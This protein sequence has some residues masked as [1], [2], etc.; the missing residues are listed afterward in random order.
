LFKINSN[1]KIFRISE[2]SIFDNK[3]INIKNSFIIV[4]LVFLISCN[5]QQQETTYNS[6]APKVVE[7]KG[8]VVPKDSMAIPKSVSAGNPKVIVADKSTQ[9]SRRILL[10]LHNTTAVVVDKPTVVPLR[11]NIHLAGNPKTVSAGTPKI[12]TPGRDSFSLPQVIKA[13]CTTFVPGIPEMVVAKDGFSKDQ[14]PQNFSSFTTLE[15]L[16]KGKT[17]SLLQDRNGNVWI[18]SW[19]GGVVRYDGKYFTRFTKKEGLPSNEVWSLLEDKVGNIWFGTL[20][21]VTKYDGKTFTNYTENGLLNYVSGMLED[22]DGN[23]WFASDGG[24]AWK[25]AGDTLTHYTEKEGLYFSLNSV[26]QDKYGHL[27]F[28]TFGGG[29]IEFDNKSF[30]HFTRK[31]GL[32]GNIAGHFLEDQFGN[33]WFVSSGGA[34]KYDGTTFTHYT[35]QE[36]LI[37]NGVKCV[38]QDKAGNFWFGTEGGF[39]KYDGTYFTN[40]TE[41]DGLINNVVNQIIQDSS[42]NFWIATENGLSRYNG[43]VF[44]HFT[45]KEGLSYNEI[46]SISED[47]S[48]NMWFGPNEGDLTKYDGQALTYYAESGGLGSMSPKNISGD[49]AGNFGSVDGRVVKYDGKKWFHYTE[50]EVLPNYESTGVIKDKSGNIWISFRLGGAMKYDGN[51]FT[52]LTVKEGLKNND[53]WLLF[54]DKAGNL[55]FAY[56]EGGV[57]RYDGT[58]TFTHYGEKEGLGGN[59]VSCIAEDKSGNLWFGTE[60]GLIRYDGKTFTHLTV[61]E[62]LS[63]NI[64]TSILPDRAG[65]LWIGTASG[66]NKLTAG[67]LLKLSAY[68]RSSKKKS[69]FPEYFNN[70]DSG[71]VLLKSYTYEDGF[72]GIGCNANAIFEDKKGIIWIGTNDRLTAYHSE[73]DQKD[74]IPPN[75]QLTGVALF[76]ENIPWTDLEHKKDTSFVLG[77]GVS[78]QNFKFDEI[79]NWYYI[80]EHLSLP[81]NNNYLTFSFIGITTKSP[82]QVKYRY[83]LEGLDE[84]WSALTSI[85]EATYG[86]LPPRNY[87][88]KIRA[89]NGDGYWSKEFNYSFTIRP[90]WWQTWWFRTL[91]GIAALLLF[92]GIYRWRTATLRRQKRILEQTVK[93]RTAEVVEEKAEVEKRNIVIQKEKEKSDELLLNIL[94]SEVADELKEKGYTTA[95]A[96]DEVTVLF[97]DIKGFTNVAENM[98]AQ[99]LV[100][101]INTYFSA[102]DG[103]IQKYGLEKIKTIGDAY[104]AAGGLPEKNSATAQNVIEAAID[105]QQVVEKLKQERTFLSKPYFELRIGIHTGPVVAGVVGIKK[106]QY[107]IWGD[108]VNLA[109]RMEQSGVPGKINISQHTYELVKDQFNCAYRGKIEAKNKGDIDMYFVR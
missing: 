55:W 47:K 62:G 87:I 80:P 85:N 12:C 58:K 28:G 38:F 42:G 88:F 92:Y 107:D 19:E 95:K 25:L 105:M 54:T 20:G 7:V 108:T 90:P 100:K 11:R 30:S 98:T 61:K 65:N 13:S 69:G 81:Y 52:H 36:G 66:L 43:E 96:F 45:R 23:I 94:P 1:Q 18:G 63:N 75:I 33:L 27:W 93:E 56:R 8:Y 76:N 86:N 17:V 48:G 83:K 34:T 4:I 91:V 9:A 104:I 3:R 102:F 79:S 99:E 73:G 68:A 32:A 40:F 50:K 21:G 24:G 70:N 59:S 49:S 14:N 77:N 6:F 101:E 15:G 41:E 5:E 53:V 82:H 39:S 97:S 72:L 2:I 71:E 103:I 78:V 22:R 64:V 35:V 60:K 31:D 26:F 10:L 51:N 57:T 89:M 84:N 109:A 37:N 16:L 67:S 106:F 46:Y 44:T 74:T 29:I